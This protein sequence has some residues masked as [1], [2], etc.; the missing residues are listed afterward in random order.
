M[1]KLIFIILTFVTSSAFCQVADTVTVTTNPALVSVGDTDITMVQLP[2]KIGN[3]AEIFI[4]FT[5]T[6]SGTVQMSTLSDVVSS[7]PSYA[8]DRFGFFTIKNGKFWIKLSNGADTIEVS[9]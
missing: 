7:S 2:S 9:W 3:P 5:G 8:A 4:K 1:K 6:N